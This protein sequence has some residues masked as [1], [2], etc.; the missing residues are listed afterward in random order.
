MRALIIGGTGPTG[1]HIIDGLLARQFQ[2]SMLNRG[3]RDTARIPDSV[4]RIVADPHFEETLESALTGR[5]FDVAI[6]TY[7]RLRIVANVLAGKV[8]QL[9]TVGGPPGYRGMFRPSDLMPAGLTVPTAESAPKVTTEAEHRFGYLVRQAEET[10]MEV[11]RSGR[12]S[13]THFR[14]PV[15]YGPGQI[16]PAI[17]WLVM[18]RCLDGRPFMVLPDAGL[19]V[20]SRGFE[21]NMAEML[22]LAVDRPDAAAG[23]IYNAADTVQ[24]SL[25]QWV[26]SIA[27]N[28]DYRLPIVSV[29]DAYAGPARDLI[30]LRASAH[31]QLLDTFKVRA[32]LGYEDVTAVPDAVAETVAW[33]RDHPPEED[34]AFR[35]ELAA[36]Y[37]TE[38]ALADIVEDADAAMAAVRQFNR[39]Y[40]HSYA[41]PVEPGQERDHRDR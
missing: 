32:E 29:P 18:R 4:E 8:G 33:Y 11:H 35:E 20:L 24:L 1:P 5:T 14:Y 28:M 22:L 36:H 2:V 40:H 38:D 30:P 3:S 19:T 31:H 27:A 25:A 10:V 13:A 15:V 39:D 37:A 41:H 34:E 21:R 17:V 16:R 26:E 12:S 6:A 7:G 9:V 23:Q